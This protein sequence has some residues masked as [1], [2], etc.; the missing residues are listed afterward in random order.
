MD[1]SKCSEVLSQVPLDEVAAKF[2]DFVREWL[3][4]SFTELLLHE[5]TALCDAFYHPE[6]NED[7]IYLG[8]LVPVKAKQNW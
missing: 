6:K 4:V 2:Q 1:K 8:E 3:R 7:F 5:T